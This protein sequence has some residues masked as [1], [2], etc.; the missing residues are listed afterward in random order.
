[1]FVSRG[2]GTNNGLSGQINLPPGVNL[3]G[4][5]AGLV[6]AQTIVPAGQAPLLQG[7]I[8]AGG[9]NVISG[10]T[11]QGSATYGV[12]IEN[13]SN[14]TVSDNTFSEHEDEH[15]FMVNIGGTVTISGNT[16]EDPSDVG[17]DILDCENT[18]TNGDLIIVDNIFRNDDGNSIDDLAD[19]EPMGTSVM[20]IT[21]SRNKANGVNPGDFSEGFYVD[22]AGT[23]QVTVTV[24]DNELS[25]FDDEVIGVHSRED[26]STISGSITGNMFSDIFNENAIHAHINGGTMA[27]SGNMIT[28]ANGAYMVLDVEDDG[29]TFIVENNQFSGTGNSAIEFDDGSDTL[30]TKMA[31]RNNT[32]SGTFGD[33]FLLVWTGD[34]RFCLEIIG[35]TVVNQMTIVNDGA[36]GDFDLEQF[37]ILSSLNNGATISDDGDI[38]NVEDGACMIP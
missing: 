14:V 33:D 20:N 21:F 11:I 7:P 34:A 28:N 17:S 27:I 3:I 32:V 8:V 31:L 30:E 6:V 10:L 26:D 25:N 5:G 4:E 9:N 16:F 29:G 18:D 19:I 13:V 15:V 12:Q 2:N 36:A 37:N 35:N 1:M 24:E 38:N 23:S 22:C